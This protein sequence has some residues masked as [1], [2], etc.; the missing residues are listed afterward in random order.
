M[1]VVH[2][3]KLGFSLHSMF[4]QVSGSV[5]SVQVS[6]SPRRSVLVRL[7]SLKSTSVKSAPRRFVLVRSASVRITSVRSAQVSGSAESIQLIVALV[8]VALILLHQ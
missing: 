8:K 2:K 3:L 6:S 5:E 1:T 7:T 4:S